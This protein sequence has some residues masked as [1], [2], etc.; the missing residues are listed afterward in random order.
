VVNIFSRWLVLLISV[1]LT[2]PAIAAVSAQLSAQSIDE[3]ETVRLLIKI[4]DT[5]QSQTL[6]LTGLQA[7]FHVMNTSTASRSQFLNGRGQSW[8][9]YQITL[10]PKRTG[11][12]KIPSIKVGNEQTPTLELEV[13]PLSEQTRQVIDQLVFFE[14]SI[15]SNEIY[16]QGQLILTRRLLYSQGVQL[17]SDLPGAPEIPNAVVLSLGETSSGSTERNGK[18]Y[19][20]VEQKYAIFPESSGEFTIPGISIT[21]SVRLLEGNRVSRKG[22]RVATH[23]ERITVLPVPPNYPE[24]QPWLPAENVTLYDVVSPEH[25]AHQ[26]GDTLTHELL[27][28]IEGNIGS[29][30]S[31]LALDLLDE[32]FRVYPQAPVIED[33]TTTTTVKGSRLQTISLVPLRPGLLKLPI[34]ELVWWDTL[35]SEV[36]ISRTKLQTLSISGQAIAATQEP[37]PAEQQPTQE[38]DDTPQQALTGLSWDVLLPYVAGGFAILLFAAGFSV[39]RRYKGLWRSFKPFPANASVQLRQ[40]F[41][42]RD[43]QQIHNALALHL[44]DHYACPSHLAFQRFSAAAD[45]NHRAIVS[46]NQHLYGKSADSDETSSSNLEAAL[47]HLQSAVAQLAR[48]AVRETRNALPDLYPQPF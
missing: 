48:P 37:S 44:A 4:T 45:D 31:P 7:D 11:T 21:A 24:D 35:N 27:I 29:I 2:L 47:A 28:H 12:L 43:L 36:K 3:L 18:A 46:L 16:V 25:G 9:D 17:Y 30:S 8:V 34:S 14:N 15:S 1:T 20:V 6:D 13:H 32:D 41:S 38:T 26:V 5:R 19:G 42:S 22:V 10:Q 40:A 33:D 39:L 23:E